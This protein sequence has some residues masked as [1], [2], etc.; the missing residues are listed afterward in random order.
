MNYI[1]EPDRRSPDYDPDKYYPS[2][3]EQENAYLDW[4]DDEMKEQRI[5]E[6]EKLGY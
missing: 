1:K 6:A 2:Y 3:E 4:L 5:R